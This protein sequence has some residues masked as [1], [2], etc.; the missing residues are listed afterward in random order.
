[1]NDMDFQAKPRIV[2]R[3]LENSSIPSH[4]AQRVVFVV[5]QSPLNARNVS[6]MADGLG[7]WPK[8]VVV[9]FLFPSKLWGYSP[10]LMILLSYRKVHLN[11]ICVV[12]N[13]AWIQTCLEVKA[14]H[15]FCETIANYG[16]T[17]FLIALNCTAMHSL[18]WSKHSVFWVLQIK[19]LSQKICSTHKS[20]SS[21]HNQLS[22]PYKAIPA[23]ERTK[24]VAQ[25]K[26]TL[27]S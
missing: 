18:D 8:E 20:W 1:M 7:S 21:P 26:K 6:G 23:A 22:L 4:A 12:K 25:L 3:P 9:F 24:R 13:I 15:H 10:L 14:Q 27:Y 5:F 19:N 17:K 16:L 11:P 2:S